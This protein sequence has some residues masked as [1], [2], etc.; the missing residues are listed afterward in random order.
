MIEEINGQV[1]C[2]FGVILPHQLWRL[3]LQCATDPPKG[4]YQY[5]LILPLSSARSKRKQMAKRIHEIPGFVGIDGNKSFERPLYQTIIYE[6]QRIKWN[7]AKDYLVWPTMLQIALLLWWDSVAR[8]IGY[9]HFHQIKNFT[10]IPYNCFAGSSSSM[11]GAERYS[12]SSNSV[13][14]HGDIQE[15]EQKMLLNTSDFVAHAK[16]TWVNLTSP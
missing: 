12:R 15:A 16:G 13:G 1:D 10:L 9:T 7:I 11:S 4:Q 5:P 6:T 3:H 8:L 2:F 14:E